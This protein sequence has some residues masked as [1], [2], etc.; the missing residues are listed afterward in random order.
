MVDFAVKARDMG[1]RYIGIC[2]DAGPHHVRSMAEALGRTPAA[3]K[4]Q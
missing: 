3:G 1:I 4:Y 2:C